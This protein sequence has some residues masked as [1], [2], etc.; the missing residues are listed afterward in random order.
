MVTHLAHRNFRFFPLC[1]RLGGGRWRWG[2]LGILFIFGPNSPWVWFPTSWYIGQWKPKNEVSQWNSWEERGELPSIFRHRFTRKH[3]S[4][5]NRASV[6]EV[7]HCRRGPLEDVG[8]QRTRSKTGTHTGIEAFCLSD[9][10]PMTIVSSPSPL[11]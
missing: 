10:P 2:F 8:E 11:K 1:V 9:L 5:D 7:L 6:S 4:S 3:E